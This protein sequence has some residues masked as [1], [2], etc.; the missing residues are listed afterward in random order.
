MVSACF[1]HSL[2]SGDALKFENVPTLTLLCYVS[3]LHINL[4]LPLSL[5]THMKDFSVVSS[6][7]GI[8]ARLLCP[9]SFPG[10]NTRAG[11]HFLLQ[12]IPQTQESNP[13][14]WRFLH[15]Q[16]DSLP[17][18]HLGSPIYIKYVCALLR[19]RQWH[20]TPVL[21]PGKS[22]GRRGLVGCS[23]WGR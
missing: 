16:A 12:R 18:R 23:P 6:T 4:K 21:L 5:G 3:A 14:L 7:K 22:H 2:P 10:K 11:C 1:L 17:V 19:R 15:W 13:C 9:W 8:N 20:P